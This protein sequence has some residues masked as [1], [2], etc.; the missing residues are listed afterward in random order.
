MRAGPLDPANLAWSDV[1]PTV[2]YG[3]EGHLNICG[4]KLFM[5]GSYKTSFTSL[6]LIEKRCI[7]IV[8]CRF[9]VSILRQPF[10]KR[11]ADNRTRGNAESR[12]A[13]LE[14]RLAGGEYIDLQCSNST[15]SYKL[16]HSCYWRQSQQNSFGYFR[17]HG[18]CR[19]WQHPEDETTNRTCSN[20]ELGR[21]GENREVRWSVFCYSL[22][23]KLANLLDH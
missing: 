21:S 4:V 9:A 11:T 18:D 13:C 6:Q 10:H 16:E 3:K 22:N 12:A 14:G 23:D 19:Q 5:D 2:N 7:G 17:E 8:G 15:H 20:N 1:K